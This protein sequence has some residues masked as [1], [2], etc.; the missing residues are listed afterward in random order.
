MINRSYSVIAL[1]LFISACNKSTNLLVAGINTPVPDLTTGAVE[2]QTKTPTPATTNTPVSREFIIKAEFPTATGSERT[3]KNYS[4]VS[5]EDIV[6]GKLPEEER[7]YIESNEIFT[8]EVIPAN[9]PKR[10]SLI[11]D[12]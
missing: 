9:S 1:F 7:K 11:K 10:D 5:F 6:G 2:V 4:K 8:K 12:K 3:T